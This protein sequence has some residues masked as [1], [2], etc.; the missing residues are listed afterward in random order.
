MRELQLQ[1]SL[2]SIFSRLQ[3]IKKT[4]WAIWTHLFIQENIYSQKYL[5]KKFIWEISSILGLFFMNWVKT[6]K[7]LLNFWT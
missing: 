4:P 1:S 5:L 2:Y 7:N 6:V 3:K